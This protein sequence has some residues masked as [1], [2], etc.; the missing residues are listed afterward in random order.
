M[1]FGFTWKNSIRPLFQNNVSPPPSPRYS[2]ISLGYDCS[3]AQALKD[4]GIRPYALPFDWVVSSPNSLERYFR[5]K[6]SLFHQNLVYNHNKTRLIDSYGFEFPHDYPLLSDVL[7]ISFSSVVTQNTIVDYWADYH[8][9][10]SAKYRRRIDRFNAILARPAPLIVLCR[11]DVRAIPKIKA[12]FETY[13][14][15][16]NVFFVNSTAK[17]PPYRFNLTNGFGTYTLCCHTEENGQWNETAV[18]KTALD[19]AVKRFIEK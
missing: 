17:G 1:N 9:D 4:M 19:A 12:L 10:A 15:K 5:D 14:G 11:Y 8:V 6:F 16:S 2:V 7:D 3:P 18:W 13:Y